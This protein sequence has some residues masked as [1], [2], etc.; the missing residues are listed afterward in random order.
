ME[1]PQ[2]SVRSWLTDAIIIALLTF[3]AYLMALYYEV[4][5]CKYFEILYYFVSIDT[6]T[7]LSSSPLIAVILSYVLIISVTIYGF[8]IF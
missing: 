5:F 3:V 6:T 4:G 1:T 8:F 2:L 7:L